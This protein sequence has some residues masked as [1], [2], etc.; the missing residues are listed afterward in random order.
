MSAASVPLVEFSDLRGYFRTYGGELHALG[1][2]TLDIAEHRITGMV[3][4]T[5]AG[6]SISA[7][8]IPGLK[9]DNLVITSGEIRYRGEDL[10]AAS[11]RRIERL[12]GRSITVVFQDPRSALNPV[13]TVGEQISRVVRQH[14]NL[15]RAEARRRALDALSRVQIPAPERRLKQYPHEMS[16]GMAQR[17]MIA[18]ALVHQPELLI[19][20]EPT[21][22]LDVTTQAEIMDL[23]VDLMREENLT[24]L[25]ITHDIG[26]VAEVCDDAAVMYAGQVAEYGPVSEVLAQ[27]AHPYTR[28]LLRASLSVEDSEI[29]DL[30]S[31]PGT[32]PD[33]RHP[34][35]GC[36][37]RPRCEHA[38]DRCLV[39]PDMVETGGRHRAK[40]HYA[41]DLLTADARR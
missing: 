32:V 9:P 16:G 28:Q 1:G 33:M 13:F 34:P 39:E 35:E 26:V 30:Y 6:K 25:L 40:C 38:T 15:G 22:G 21:T 37:F 3:G 8:L 5:G 2:I 12:R 23:V 31:I 10:L 14:A 41:L 18:M 27:P 36:Y 7:M 19:L 11:R 20:D 17:V 24:V 4:E 29:G